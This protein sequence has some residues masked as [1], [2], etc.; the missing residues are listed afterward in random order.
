MNHTMDAY[1]RRATLRHKLAFA[2][3]V[4]LVTFALM[5]AMFVAQ[6]GPTP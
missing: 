3:K 1:T 6:I 4:A 5:L 2:G